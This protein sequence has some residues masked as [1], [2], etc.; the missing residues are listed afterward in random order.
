M[1]AVVLLGLDFL[2]GKVLFTFVHFEGDVSSF[3]GFG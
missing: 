3:R 2:P 1:G